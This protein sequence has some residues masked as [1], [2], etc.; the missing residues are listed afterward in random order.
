LIRC[1]IKD[2]LSVVAILV[3]SYLL[4]GVTGY[5]KE[6]FGTP[7]DFQMLQIEFLALYLLTRVRVLNN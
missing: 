5:L 1:L 4:Y 7:S 2:I 6:R 3:A